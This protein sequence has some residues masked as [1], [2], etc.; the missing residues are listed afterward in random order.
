MRPAERLTA[1]DLAAHGRQVRI[2]ARL[3]ALA[4]RV[5]GPNRY[6]QLMRYLATAASIRQQPKP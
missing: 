2:L 4:L 1:G 3:F 5:V 6:F